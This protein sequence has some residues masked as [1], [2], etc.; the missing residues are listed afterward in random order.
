MFSLLMTRFHFEPFDS[1]SYIVEGHLAEQI[2]H[3]LVH[4][5]GSRLQVGLLHQHRSG[6]VQAALQ[7]VANHLQGPQVRRFSHSNQK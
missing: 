4:A 6:F 7:N 2:V 3:Q 1:S 5:P